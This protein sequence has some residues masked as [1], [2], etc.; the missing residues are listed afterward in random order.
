V[1]GHRYG[2]SS[3]ES[4]GLTTR[5]PTLYNRAPASGACST[6]LRQESLE[7]GKRE[8]WCVAAV[9]SFDLQAA[10]DK[11]TAA[12]ATVDELLFGIQKPETGLVVKPNSFA[13]CAVAVTMK[14]RASRWFYCLVDYAS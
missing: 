1:F 12:P 3:G 14:R 5:K 6:F 4:T 9:S 8:V 7:Q 2:E 10:A 11:A 13:T